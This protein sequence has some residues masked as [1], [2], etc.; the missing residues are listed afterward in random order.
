MKTT[1]EAELKVGEAVKKETIGEHYKK[2]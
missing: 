2:R 1:A